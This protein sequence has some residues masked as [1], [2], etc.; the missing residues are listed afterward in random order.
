MAVCY[1]RADRADPC[2]AVSDQRF[3]VQ[4]SQT[5]VG[6]MRAS[7]GVGSG[8]VK[9][10]NRLSKVVAVQDNPYDP[11]RHATVVF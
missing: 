6:V 8:K 9:D 1:N 2:V 4:G 5:R 10:V 7:G 11:S 3:H